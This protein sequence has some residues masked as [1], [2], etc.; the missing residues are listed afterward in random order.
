MSLKVGVQSRNVVFDEEP[1]KGFA[2]LKQSG[3]DCC[4]FSL[5]YYL[6]NTDLYQ[7]NLNAFFDCTAAELESFFTPHKEG[8]EAAGIRINQMHMPYPTFVP[9][10]KKE[11]NDYLWKE[12]G[13][14]SME[15]C[16][17]FGCPHIVVHGF[18]LERYYGSEQAEWE[19]TEEFLEYLAPM[20]KEYGI[21][22]CMENLYNGQGAHMKEGPGC[23]AV[24][25]ARRIDA[26]NEKYGAEVLGFC[27]D[28][29]H[30]N[31][32]GLDPYRFLTT[33]GERLK[34]LHI[35]E[36][37]G[38]ADLHQLPFTFTRTRENTSIMDWNGFLRGLKES[39]FEGTLSFETAP[40]LDC[41]PEGLREEVL[42]MIASI[43][44]H[45]ASEIENGGR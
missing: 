5:N 4:D 41:F 25:A 8:A 44:R 7:E 14:K 20:A 38:V 26:M 16:R 31:L 23:N 2:L 35:H 40:V 27:Y 11:V 17:F 34:V 29:G 12:V 13:P 21:T 24:K 28:T 19:K 10:A 1:A 9:G 15:I 22:I 3:F 36:N 18:K 32:V 42:R 43:G 45:F 6:K 39:G 33:L 37:D 30:G